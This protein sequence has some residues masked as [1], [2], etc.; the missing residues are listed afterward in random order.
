[1]KNLIYTLILLAIWGLPVSVSAQL[2]RPAYTKDSVRV[3]QIS[4][5]VVGQRSQEP[6]PYVQVQVNHSRMG[7]LTNQDGFYSLPVT[8]NDTIYFSHVAYRPT[9]LI[10]AKYLQEYKGSDTYIYVVNY[11]KDDTFSVRPIYI[12][13]YKNKD[14]VV[15]AIMNMEV[16]KTSPDNI[17]RD[18]LDPKVMD[19]IMASLPKDGEERYIVGRQTY[20]QNFNR[21]NLM[22]VAG[23]D[24]MAAVRLLQYIVQK[25]KTKNNKDLN[26]WERGE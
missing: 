9:K 10:I 7:A 19:A 23:V 20:Y 18:N 25:A 26:Y 17:A 11:M 2:L 14:E 15:A 1:M 24:A 3:M 5:M 16:D 8:E 13:P 12:Y 22:P 4:G 6:I 21:Q